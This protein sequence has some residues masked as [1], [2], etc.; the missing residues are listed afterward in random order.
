MA[1]A[2]AQ[3]GVAKG[4]FFPVIRL[5]GVG[6]FVSADVDQLFKW[7]SHVWSLGPSVSLP[8]FAGGRNKAGLARAKK[9]HEE[10]TYNYQQ[11]VLVALGEVQETLTGLKHFIRQVEAS[12]RAAEA[13]MRASAI[14]RVRYDGGIS[15]YLEVVDAERSALQIRREAARSH[16][17]QRIATVQLIKALGGSW[18]EAAK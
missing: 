17:Q 6:G 10:A 7:D 9:S 3:I 15:G 8:I 5:T 16:G 18:D 2:N 11:Q 12:D 4:A 13:A 14:A 1:S